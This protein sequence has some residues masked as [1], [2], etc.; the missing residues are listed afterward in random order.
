MSSIVLSGLSWTRP[1]GDQFLQRLDLSFG[2]ERTGLVGRNGV[3]K[4]TLLNIIAGVLSP[5]AGSLSID[6]KV[7]LVRQMLDA[8]LRETVADLFGA[9]QAIELLARKAEA[10]AWKTLRRPIGQSGN[11]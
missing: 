1:E 2:P 3:G 4:T 7:V 11:G 10:P 9:R 8:G 6:G 5:S